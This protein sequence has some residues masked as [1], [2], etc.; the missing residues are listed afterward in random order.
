MPEVTP[1]YDMRNLLV[2]IVLQD[3]SFMEALNHTVCKM[4]GTLFRYR[5]KDVKLIC[6]VSKIS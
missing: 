4:A 6:K 2:E 3:H 5:Y 1:Y